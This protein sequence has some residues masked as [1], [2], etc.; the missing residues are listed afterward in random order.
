MRSI[1]RQRFEVNSLAK[2]IVR[3][4]Y[5]SVIIE[6][7]ATL[8]SIP[9]VSE[10]HRV[11]NLYYPEAYVRIFGDDQE[12]Y[13]TDVINPHWGKRVMRKYPPQSWIAALFFPWGFPIMF[14]E[15]FSFD[16]FDEYQQAAEGTAERFRDILAE[17][18]ISAQ[19]T[20][21]IG[22]M[23]LTTGQGLTDIVAMNPVVRRI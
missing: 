19:V 10:T 20:Q 2:R 17:H 3:E 14:D 5:S 8:S 15:R 7:H 6:P 22:E 16:T 4:Q 12:L 21:L 11:H 13:R 23:R 9:T 1:L 18:D